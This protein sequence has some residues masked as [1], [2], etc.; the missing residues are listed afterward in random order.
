MY[1]WASSPTDVPISKICTKSGASKPS[2]YREFGSDDGLKEA[3]LDTYGKMVS[4]KRYEIL[5]RQQPV[6]E[7]L[8]ALITYTVQDRRTLGVPDGCLLFAMRSRR[9]EFGPLTRKK[10][11]LL[12]KESLDKY[13]HW[14]DLAKTNKQFRADIPTDTAALYFDAQTGSAMQ[15]QKEGVSNKVIGDILRTAFSVLRY[16]M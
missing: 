3:V 15:L 8:E 11:D 4:A 10:I 7:V 1:Y 16:K 6:G 5:A 12:R 9:D 2:L 13:R 14:I